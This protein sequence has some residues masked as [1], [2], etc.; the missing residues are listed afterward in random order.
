L[1]GSAPL[2]KFEQVRH[3]EA[4]LSLANARSEEELLALGPAQPPLLEG[5]G[6]DEV[7]FRYVVVEPRD[8]RPQPS[9]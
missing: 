1:F 9:H 2:E 6:L 3:L 7:P 8:R 4:M 5:K